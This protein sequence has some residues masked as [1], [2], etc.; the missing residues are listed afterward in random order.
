[1][2][3]AHVHLEK[4]PYTLEWINKFIKKAVERNISEIYFLE[5]THVFSECSSLYDEMGSYNTYQ[6]EWFA[7]KKAQARPISDYLK[8]MERAKKEKLPVKLR[9]GLEVCY[10]QE[11]E[12]EIEH[13]K[14]AYPWD[15]LVG[16]IHFIDG[17]AFSHLK[18]R[19][20]EKDVELDTIYRRYYELMIRLARSGLFDGVAHPNSLQCFGAFP[21]EDYSDIYE[22]LATAL[23]ENKMYAEESSGLTINYDNMP[24]G[25]NEKMLA[26]MQKHNVKILTASDAHIPDNVGRYISEMETIIKSS[27]GKNKCTAY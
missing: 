21:P 5:H 23:A 13:M 17:W 18:Q 22:E 19:W 2:L 3:D 24:L 27:R 12:K 16:S 4:G 20:S 14:N 11:H 6:S 26:A 1:M 9:F 15:F 7:G 25:M 8:L 10:S